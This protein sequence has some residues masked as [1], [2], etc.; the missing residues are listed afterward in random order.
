MQGVE[1]C[2][3]TAVTC[4]TTAK[5]SEKIAATSAR[6]VETFKV[7]GETSGRIFNQEQAQD[8]SRK[9]DETFAK[10]GRISAKIIEISGTIAK[11]G[12]ETGENYGTTWLA[13]KATAVKYLW[14][15]E[16]GNNFG[17][18]WFCFTEKPFVPPARSVTSA[19][20]RAQSHRPRWR[21]E[22]EN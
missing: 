2:G 18:C 6:T 5:T 9:I 16:A 22:G 15:R 14:A 13:A 12:V 17:C 3:K 1:R 11:T 21:P 8:R 19:L 10:I 20:R 7:I 4:V